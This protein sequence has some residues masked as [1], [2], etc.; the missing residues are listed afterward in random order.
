MNRRREQ[1]YNRLETQRVHA[2][3]RGTSAALWFSPQL[4]PQVC[5]HLGRVSCTLTAPSHDAP[6]EPN[7]SPR[8]APGP[9]R[10]WSSGRWPPGWAWTRGHGVWHRR[11]R[12]WSPG[13]LG[14]PW[15]GACTPLQAGGQLTTAS[16][17]HPAPVPGFVQQVG[18]EF[19]TCNSNSS[20]C[21]EHIMGTQSC[22]ATPLSTPQVPGAATTQQPEC[23]HMADLPATD[24]GLDSS[25][26]G[27]VQAL[28]QADTRPHWRVARCTAVRA[29]DGNLVAA[30]LL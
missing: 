18:N 28:G 21:Q 17:P 3:R 13:P 8:T 11:A 12:A 30:E 4:L 10:S 29:Q 16:G 2:A 23:P 15:W 1:K 14:W 20:V 24:G 6:M 25:A 5:L 19:F 9:A 26:F 7:A 22:V 27:G